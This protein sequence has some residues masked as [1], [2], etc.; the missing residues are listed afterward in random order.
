MD[1][2][3][4]GSIDGSDVEQWAEAIEGRDDVGYETTVADWLRQVVFEL[5]NPKL[6][7]PLEPSRAAELKSEIAGG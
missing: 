3:L 5:A 1:R 7:A 2:Y 6:T 4:S